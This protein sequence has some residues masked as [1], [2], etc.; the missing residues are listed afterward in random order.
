LRSGSVVSLVVVLVWFYLFLVAIVNPVFTPPNVPSNPLMPFLLADAVALLW[1]PLL[2]SA[3]I[4]LVAGQRLIRASGSAQRE[5]SPEEFIRIQARAIEMSTRDRQSVSRSTPSST[6]AAPRTEIPSTRTEA[7]ET[8]AE[9]VVAKEA[10]E[11]PAVRKES[12]FTPPPTVVRE[13]AT[14]EGVTPGKGGEAAES[15][16]G[17]EVA[18][19]LG[20]VDKFKDIEELEAEK[21]AVLSLTERLEEMNR[22]QAIKRKL[23]EKLKRKYEEQVEKINQRI[24]ELSESKTA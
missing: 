1:P 10:K 23:Y 4:V 11:T 19:H 5:I 16:Q 12:E 21:A 6:S 17:L 2:I 8:P 24:G 22:N 20:P 15:G 14:K 7:A 18:S 9:K 13:A 3:P